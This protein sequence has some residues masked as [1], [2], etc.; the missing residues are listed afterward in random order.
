MNYGGGLR[1][2]SA[3]A[4]GSL[5]SRMRSGERDP[6]SRPDRLDGPRLQADIRALRKMAADGPLA[7]EEGSRSILQ[8][9]LSVAQVKNDDQGS[10][11]A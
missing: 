5:N 4:S 2:S 3:T 8:A 7:V 10:V 1:G 11:Q 9:S 6:L